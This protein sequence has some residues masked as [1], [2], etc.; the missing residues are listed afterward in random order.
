MPKYF[1]NIRRGSETTADDEGLYLPDID[2]VREEARRSAREMITQE[3][4]TGYIHPDQSFIVTDQFGQIVLTLN[5]KAALKP[6]K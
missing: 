5:F 2:A 1:F 4:L 6:T 3:A